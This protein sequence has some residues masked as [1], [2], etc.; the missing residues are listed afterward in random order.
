MSAR[1][2]VFARFRCLP[3]CVYPSLQRR[4]D[5]GIRPYKNFVFDL[6]FA[7]DFDFVFAFAFDFAFAFAFDF[8]FAFA[9]DF[10][11]A[12][13]FA[14]A[15]ALALD[16]GGG[17]RWARYEKSCFLYIRHLTSACLR[18]D[19]YVMPSSEALQ[20]TTFFMPSGG[21]FFFLGT[22][23]FLDKQKEEGTVLVFF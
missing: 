15:L 4:A 6:D 23:F 22:F 10:A 21:S 3:P 2:Y 13:A 11:F 17:P 18:H 1:L 5:T 19:F 20:K 16:V 14:L 9:F 7:F 12:L 8:A